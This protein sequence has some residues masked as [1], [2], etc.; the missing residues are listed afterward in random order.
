MV[1]NTGLP[2]GPIKLLNG[3]QGRHSGYGRVHI[4]SHSSRMKQISG[5]GFKDVVT[6]IYSIASSFDKVAT[7]ENGRIL[8][9]TFRDALHHHVI[10]QWDDQLQVWSV[11][12]AIPKAVMREEAIIWERSVGG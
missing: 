9:L 1:A 7:Q 4:E 3:I 8:I 2:H 5:L 10:C 11:T 6:Y 12:T